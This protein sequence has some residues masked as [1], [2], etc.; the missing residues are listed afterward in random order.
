V[1]LTNEVAGGLA[2]N[3]VAASKGPRKGK[4]NRSV[5]TVYVLTGDENAPQLKAVQIKTGITDGLFT[6][7]AEGLKEGDKV[8]SGVVNN[9][10]Q[11]SA[12]TSSPFGGGFPRR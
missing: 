12:S 8:V 1:I 4:G 5:R 6:E 7:V 2:T 11:G 3:G 9:D 10:S